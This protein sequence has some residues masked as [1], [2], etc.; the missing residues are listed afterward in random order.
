MAARDILDE[1]SRVT[2]RLA[3]A[4]ALVV[5]VTAPLLEV[6]EPGL[7]R[8]LIEC[9]RAGLSMPTH[10]DFQALAVEEYLQRLADSIEARVRKRIAAVH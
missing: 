6:L 9:V 4:E 10:D 8:E 3:A 5:Q 1:I 2:A 7:G